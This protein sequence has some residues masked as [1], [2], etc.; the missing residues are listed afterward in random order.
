VTWSV[1]DNYLLVRHTG[2]LPD[3]D[4]ARALQHRAEELLAHYKLRL[5]LFDNRRTKRPADEVRLSM[6]RWLHVCPLIDRVAMLLNSLALGR[7]INV[8]AARAR[9]KIRAFSSEATARRWLSTSDSW[10]VRDVLV[11]EYEQTAYALA[12]TAVEEVVACSRLLPLP[13]P[14]D[15]ILGVLKHR[16]TMVPVLQSPQGHPNRAAADVTRRIVICCAPTA[17]IGLPATAAH[18]AEPIQMEEIVGHGARTDSSVGPLV[19][20]EP[21]ELV[22]STRWLRG[23]R[24]VR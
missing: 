22:R 1:T 23:D 19:Y 10:P 24:E 14:A 4:V 5:V 3:L 15:G 20:L 7:S 9:V 13:N 2:A 18:L 17:R 16:G 11:F 21:E 12:V 8:E 6:W